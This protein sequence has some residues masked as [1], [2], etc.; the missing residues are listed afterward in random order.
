MGDNQAV[1]ISPRLVDQDQV[2]EA[3]LA[4]RLS[5]LKDLAV[6][7]VDPL[8]VGEEV[9]QLFREHFK[10]GTGLAR[11]GD[12]DLRRPCVCI[13][14]VYFLQ[15]VDVVV[16]CICVDLLCVVFLFVLQRAQPG[17]RLLELVALLPPRNL[18]RLG[19]LALA[20]LRSRPGVLS[21][22]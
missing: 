8:R 12:E 13:L 18:H 19:R 2:C 6:A 3:R 5:Q 15:F 14:V 7:S 20:E 16:H 17:E 22:H 10:A 1:R 21:V 11:R 9:F 4:D